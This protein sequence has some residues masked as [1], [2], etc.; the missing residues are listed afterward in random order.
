MLK[1]KEPISIWYLIGLLL[2]LYGVL[3]PGA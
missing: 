2:T 1:T 3:I